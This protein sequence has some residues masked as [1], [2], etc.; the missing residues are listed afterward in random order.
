[1]VS[2]TVDYEKMYNDLKIEH[3]ALQRIYGNFPCCMALYGKLKT[4]AD[5]NDTKDVILTDTDMKYH[6]CYDTYTGFHVAATITRI[7]VMDVFF[8]S[9]ECATKALES[10]KDEFETLLKLK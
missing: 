10:F 5:L 8:A 3:E 9:H 4:F 2:E 6:I 7:G 1:M